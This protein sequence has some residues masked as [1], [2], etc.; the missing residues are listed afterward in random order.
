MLSSD[1]HSWAD[2]DC[3]ILTAK[4]YASAFGGR[5]KILTYGVYI[6]G[7]LAGATLHVGQTWYLGY[8]A[9]QYELM[10]PATVPVLR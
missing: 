9:N 1:L 5:G 8:W 4:L 2:I 7:L 3:T 6:G 10:D